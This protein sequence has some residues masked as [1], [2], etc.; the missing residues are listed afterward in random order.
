MW[1]LSKENERNNFKLNN[2]IDL[3]T[4]DDYHKLFL[5]TPKIEFSDTGIDKIN[6][7]PFTEAYELHELFQKYFNK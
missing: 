7:Q 6:E 4:L 2:S 1:L 5:S 3:T